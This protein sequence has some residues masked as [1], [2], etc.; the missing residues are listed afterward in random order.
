MRKHS[1]FLN[2]GMKASAAAIA[3]MAAWPAAAQDAT[4]NLAP[5]VV[6][7]DGQE[8][9]KGPVKGYVAKSSATATKTGTPIVETQQSI[10]V[11]AK[12][13][14]EAQGLDT[15]SEVL[16]STPGVVGE[17][18]GADGRFDSPLIRGF[19]AGQSQYLNG[20]KIMR[21]FGATSTEIYGL[22]RVEV[23]R[24]PA[25][26]LYG[27]GN[28]GG[29]INMV[30][31]RPQF[32]PLREVGIQ[33]G[34]Y[35]TYGT[36][37]DFSDRI[38]DTDFAY[39]V[40]GV[41]RNGGM[42]TDDL[43]NDRYFIAP[44]FTWKPDEDTTITLLTS[45]QHDNPDTPSGLPRELTLNGGN[46]LP[47]DFSVGDPSF[48]DSDRT[49]TNIGYEIDHRFDE[50]WSFHQS[51]RYSNLDWEFQSLGMTG[52][53]AGTNSILRGTT[54]QDENTNSYN[55][56]T[57]LQA[58][59][60]TGAL[61]HNVVMGLDV[62]YFNDNTLSEFGSASPISVTNPQYGGSFPKVVTMWSD[63]D[64]QMWQA[65]LYVQDELKY[66]NWRATLGLR[67][68]WAVIS[69]E[70]NSSYA[71][72]QSLDQNDQKLTGRVGLSYLFDNGISP[73]ASYATSFE[74]I[75][76]TG[77]GGTPL[78][79]TTGEQFEVGVKYQPT[80]FDGFF[81][82]AAY[83]LKQ[84]NVAV[85]T[86]VG[87]VTT[88][89]QVAGVKVQGIELEGVISLAEGLDMRAA[90]SYANGEVFGD[91]NSGNR[92][93]RLPEHA[94]SLWLD[95]TFQP[96][97]ALEGF[98]L[99][100]GVRYLGQRYSNVANTDD[101]PNL[102]LFDA[103]IHYQKDNIKAS[104]NIENL[105]DKKYVASCGFYGCA[106]GDGRTFMGKLSVSW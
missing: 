62:R 32:E 84:K 48:D 28:P 94:A 4:T 26:V 106:Y 87:G 19:D 25:S 34:S 88:Y 77:V 103:S 79:P 15:L 63:N 89:E 76:V 104:L 75:A 36:F 23:L 14:I 57:R 92:P 33:G 38:G 8:N 27:Q 16:E 35:E 10:S 11:I 21:G 60:D 53:D 95:Y 90:Y 41:A 43:Q 3:I 30:S 1:K 99:G 66:E 22:E 31:K 86:T 52:Y 49:V 93:A 98:G 81:S 82:I 40:T 85:S 74:P 58:E 73:Y 7:A 42:V 13:Q 97:T 51:M 105:A 56:D 50:V 61:E 100:G 83:D 46:S 55:V 29:L 70:H 18:Y 17:P 37:F 71:G 59:F 54:Y 2:T 20:M 12:D 6:Q 39:R 96:D 68:D 45:V 65:G 102:A 78:K 69:G 24:G 80:G 67:H 72:L 44:A 101:L 64:S 5:I 47:R 9:P 91:A